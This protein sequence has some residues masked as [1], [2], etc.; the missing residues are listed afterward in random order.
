MTEVYS[1]HNWGTCLGELVPHGSFLNVDPAREIALGDIVAVAFKHEGLFANFARHLSDEGMLGVTKIYMGACESASGEPVILVGQL[2]PPMVSPIPR[3]AVEA[4]HLVVGGD[5]PA[6]IVRTVS[7]SDQYAFNLI[8]LL[9]RSSAQ[10]E[11][12]NPHWRPPSD[13]EE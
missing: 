5:A 10:Q 6:G 11:P 8:A 2:N 12:I 3:S 13:E 1:F 4:L 7:E 9:G